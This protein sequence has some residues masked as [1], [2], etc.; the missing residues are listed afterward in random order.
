MFISSFIGFVYPAFMSFKALES[1]GEDDDK[2][3]LTYLVIYSLF[4]SLEG[5]FSIITSIIPFYFVLKL[6]F[7]V[8]LFHPST[9]GATTLYEKVLLPFI[10]PYEEKIDQTAYEITDEIKKY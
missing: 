3:W 8:F 10:K 4:Q 6:A 9:Q 1:K 2:Q 5:V 7:H